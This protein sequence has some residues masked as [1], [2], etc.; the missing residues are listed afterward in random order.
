MARK[1]YME[2]NQNHRT[3]KILADIK[4]S[5]YKFQVRISTELA[6]GVTCIQFSEN[7]YCMFTF[8]LQKQI[9]FI[10]MLLEGQLDGSKSEL[11]HNGVDI[12]AKD[13]EHV[14]KTAV[15]SK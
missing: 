12:K 7:S 1:Q 10:Q 14:N 6:V 2:I 5:T 15:D 11:I 3:F 4:Q 13:N 9:D 8:F